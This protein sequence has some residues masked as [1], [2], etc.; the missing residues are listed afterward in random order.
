VKNR[1][2]KTLKLRRNLNAAYNDI[3]D[4]HNTVATD[5]VFGGSPE[6]AMLRWIS[7]GQVDRKLVVNLEWEFREQ[8]KSQITDNLT[9]ATLAFVMYKSKSHKYWLRNLIRR[10][11]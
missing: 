5:S 11:R 3:R 9:G 8:W 6:T 2:T 7:A 10:C 4:R 1:I